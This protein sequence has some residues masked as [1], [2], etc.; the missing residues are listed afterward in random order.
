VW[1]YLRNF[2]VGYDAS[3]WSLADFAQPLPTPST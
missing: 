3:I 2:V 1:K